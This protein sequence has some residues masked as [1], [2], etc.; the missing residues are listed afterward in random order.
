MREE[1]EVY[2]F[3]DCDWASR[4]W[5]VSPF[6]L[7]TEAA[8]GMPLLEWVS[9]TLNQIEKERKG[10][11]I[12]CLHGLWHSRNKLLFENGNL[13]SETILERAAISFAEALCPTNSS[14]S[15]QELL[16]GNQSPSGWRTPPPD[17]YKINVD[18]ASNNGVKGGV[19][20]VIRDSN[21][22]VVAAATLEVAPAL[23]V[24]EAKAFAFYQRVNIAAQTCFL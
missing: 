14:P 4:F 15:I 23:S 20:V 6:N 12:C 7:R 8:A 18:A 16:P 22:V 2:L 13:T 19:G 17:R 11:F 3:R 5:F 10:L 21:G 9:T 24:R 1:S